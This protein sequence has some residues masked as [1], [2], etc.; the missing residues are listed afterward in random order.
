M[1][2]AFFFL[3]DDKGKKS[4]DTLPPWYVRQ[5]FFTKGF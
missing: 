3:L 5:R 1:L 2:M 4:S